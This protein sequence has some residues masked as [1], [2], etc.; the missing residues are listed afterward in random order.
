MLHTTNFQ[1]SVDRTSRSFSS[2]EV[3]E[4][5]GVSGSYLRLLSNHGLGPTPDLGIPARL[6]CTLRQIND[7][8]AYHSSGRLKEALKF[9]PQRREGEKLQIIS[10]SC[11]PPE[12]HYIVLSDS[13]ALQD[14]RSWHTNTVENKT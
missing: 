14:S 11:R 3:A 13:L 7:L 1:F 4:I 6:S 9:R 5:L 10:V 12:N 2:G 8:G